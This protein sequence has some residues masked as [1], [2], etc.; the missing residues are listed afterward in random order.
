MTS[1]LKNRQS[2]SSKGNLRPLLRVI[3]VPSRS[4][5]AILVPPCAE[6]LALQEVEKNRDGGKFQVTWQLDY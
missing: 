1:G 4:I 6:G 2:F 5:A 3:N